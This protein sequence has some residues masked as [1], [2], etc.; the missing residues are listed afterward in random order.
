[1]VPLLLAEYLGVERIG[2]SYGL[3]RLFQAMSN[4]IGPVVGGVLSDATGSFSTSFVVM[5]LIMSSGSIFVFFK[6]IIERKCQPANS[7]E[8]C[9]E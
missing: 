9:E 7:T 8:G 1:M 2:S 5:G 3:I 4:L 6:P